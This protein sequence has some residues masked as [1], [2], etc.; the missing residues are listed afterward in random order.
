MVTKLFTVNL[1]RESRHISSYQNF[2]H[3]S[4]SVFQCYI[5][6]WFSVAFHHSCWFTASSG[7]KFFCFITLSTSV[8]YFISGLPLL[9]LASSDQVIICLG[10]LLSSMHVNATILTCYFPFFPKL[11]VLFPFFV[12]ITLFL[13]F[14]S[15]VVL[16]AHLQKSISVL[17]SFFFNL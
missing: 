2:L 5:G 4:I 7:V 1:C 6:Y 16:A 12:V 8:S 10:H 11:F 9:L 17:D 15:L 3:L 14:N 13:I